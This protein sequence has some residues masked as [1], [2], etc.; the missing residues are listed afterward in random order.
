[1]HWAILL[2][3]DHVNL[4]LLLLDKVLDY[5]GTAF[6]FLYPPPINLFNRCYRHVNKISSTYEHSTAFTYKSTPLP[7]ARIVTPVCYI[8]SL[9]NILSYL[10]CSYYFDRVEGSSFK[11]YVDSRVLPGRYEVKAGIFQDFSNDVA[12]STPTKFS[13]LR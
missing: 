2:P 6:V 3:T 1:M 10:V 7:L 11:S 4:S 12:W 9:Y 13:A 8:P 5:V